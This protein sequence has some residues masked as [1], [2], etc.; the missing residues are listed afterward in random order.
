MLFFPSN[1]CIT[2][3]ACVIWKMR[4]SICGSHAIKLI[5]C[6]WLSLSL[7]FSSHSANLMFLR[8]GMFE[9]P[10]SSWME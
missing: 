6:F 7:N 5:Y 4:S 1:L 8:L 3:S 2:A 10:I 9:L